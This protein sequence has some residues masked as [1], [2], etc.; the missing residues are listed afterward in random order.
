MQISENH[1]LVRGPK[2][3]SNS[4][5][6]ALWIRLDDSVR[7]SLLYAVGMWTND[8]HVIVYFQLLITVFLYISSH[9][10]KP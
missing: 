5:N 8:L 6:L 2:F 7:L 1:H 3:A 4:Y 9:I 10:E